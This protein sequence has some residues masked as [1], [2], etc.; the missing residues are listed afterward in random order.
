MQTILIDYFIGFI[1]IAVIVFCLF[2]RVL[3]YV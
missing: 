1:I 3:K 2:V